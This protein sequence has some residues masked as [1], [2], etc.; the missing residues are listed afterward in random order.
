MKTVVMTEKE[1]DKAYEVI[2]NNMRDQYPMM[3]LGDMQSIAMF[4]QMFKDRYYK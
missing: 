3:T 1:F 2:F 4:V